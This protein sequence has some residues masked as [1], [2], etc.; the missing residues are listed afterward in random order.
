MILHREDGWVSYHVTGNGPV[1]VLIHAI[2][3]GRKMWQYQLAALGPRARTITFDAR[4]VGESSDLARGRDP[5]EQI[6]DDIAAILDDLG[7]NSA[8]V[9]GVSF[10]GV[11]AQHFA[12]RHPER[13]R[14]L[15]VVDS[16][17]D[18]RPT[19]LSRAAWLAS[20]YAGSVSNYLPRPALAALM[21]TAYSRWPEAA[22]VLSDAVAELRPWQ[23]FR[24]RL[25]INLVNYLPG[26]AGGSYPVWF[27]VGLNSWWRSRQFAEEFAAKVPRTTILEVPNSTDPTPLCQ[28]E[29]FTAILL[30]ALDEVESRS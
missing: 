13:V 19:S 9:C 16:Y 20:V 25:A 8:F 1:V 4:G 30:H 5:K 22:R 10:G 24:T 2:S 14:A 26:V 27:V 18:S 12:V 28:P 23:A 11:I 3:T 15:M 21:R 6:A 7:E 29:A 17:G